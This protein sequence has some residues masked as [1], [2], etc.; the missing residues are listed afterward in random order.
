MQ[1]IVSSITP[2]VVNLIVNGHEEFQSFGKLC[3]CLCC[4]SSR[5]KRLT[6]VELTALVES[7][8][9]NVSRSTLKV[10]C[11]AAGTAQRSARNAVVLWRIS[12][13]PLPTLLDSA[14]TVFTQ[15]TNACTLRISVR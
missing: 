9:G 13:R 12:P 5:L 14:P 1:S 11:M 3:V 2:V 4:C 8:S 7:V 10:G 15:R 6:D